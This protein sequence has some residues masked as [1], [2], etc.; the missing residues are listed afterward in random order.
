[1]I[2]CPAGADMESF[3]WRLSIAEVGTSGPF[4]HFAGIDRTLAI[5]A[6]ELE[7]A[8]EGNPAPVQLD[9]HS[10]P[11]PFSGEA[12]VIGT[13]VA[14]P[15]TDLNA[16]V[17]RGRFRAEMTPL[18]G[19]ESLEADGGTIVIVALATVELSHDGRTWR[20]DRLDAFFASAGTI[21]IGRAGGSERLGHAVRFIA[22]D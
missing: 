10:P 13:P 8:I 18:S 7:L 17:R 2:A 16:M 11:F 6:G 9:R 3:L 1:M 4:S 14:G 5:V 12:P 15:V 20:L 21:R 22:T 19:G